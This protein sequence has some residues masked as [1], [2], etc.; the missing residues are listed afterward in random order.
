MQ[1]EYAICN[2]EYK[3]SEHDLSMLNEYNICKQQYSV[4]CSEQVIQGFHTHGR[5][6]KPILLLD[7]WRNGLCVMRRQTWFCETVEMLVWLFLA[8]KIVFSNVMETD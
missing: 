7:A 1:L 5:L 6:V 8:A 4:A 2:L 3:D